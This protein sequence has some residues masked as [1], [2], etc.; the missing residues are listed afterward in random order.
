MAVFVLGKH[1]EPL[2]P[3]SEKRGRLLL[4]R[5]RA[6][7]H[8]MY[9]FTIRLVD[10]ASGQTQPLQLKL[11]PGSKQ[12]GLAIVR[13]ADSTATVVALVELKHRG[14]TICKALKQRSGFRRRRRSANLR[15]RAPRFDNRRK[16]EGWLAPSLQHRVDTVLAT[17]ARLRA[18]APITSIVQELVR[19]DTQLMENPE[20]SGIEYQQGTLE[21]CEVREYLLAKWG[22]KCVYCDAEGVPLNIDHVQPN[23]PSG[24]QHQKMVRFA[25]AC[26]F[27]FN[28][29]LALQQKLHTDG[30]K[31]LSYAGLCEAL[32][33]WKADPET[34]WL[35][36]NHSQILQQSLKDLDR[37]YANFFAKRAEFPRFKKKGVH[38]GFRFPQGY[39]LDQVNDRI[40]LPKL[41]WLRYRNSREV[42]G[43]LKN[44]T[45][46]QSSGKWFVA[47]QTQREVSEPVHP[48]TLVIGIDLGVACFAAT[49]DGEMIAPLNSF[50]KHEVRLR[51]YHRAMSRKQKFSENW[52]KAKSKV[53]K[54]H[55]HIANCRKHFLHKVST[56][57]SKNHATVFVE[58]LQVSNMSKSAAGPVEK[59]G[60]NVRAK[61]G[62][63]RSIL[64]QGWFEVRR[65]IGYKLVWRGGRLTAVPAHHTS[66]TCPHCGHI[67]S[68]NRKTQAVFLC[69]VCGLEG[70]ADVIAAVNIRDRGL[71]LLKTQGQDFARIAC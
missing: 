68:D 64:D 67:S 37:A 23:R 22:R 26:R 43:T 15:Y 30:E 16:P 46:S 8:R 11:D 62:L 31:K 1:K 9:P 14:A 19:F 57:I 13:E 20:I 28:Q 71:V 24:E 21:G 66:Q 61:S 18:S 53:Q 41:G 33:E 10:R 12:T 5:G 69:V 42:L 34:A 45:V 32:L 70:N 48:S 54:L 25:G 39:K 44:V 52:K 27:V 6:R 3:C 51:R 36:E 29:A 59:P 58:D 2:M 35:R 4:K 17:V 65:Q 47:I 38:D 49:S 60:K 7:V 40:F 50:K 56:T 55:T 63:N